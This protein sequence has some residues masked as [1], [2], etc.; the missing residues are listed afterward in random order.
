MKGVYYSLFNGISVDNLL[1]SIASARKRANRY[2]D[3]WVTNEGFIEFL[4]LR[5]HHWVTI[6]HQGMSINRHFDLQYLC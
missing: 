1:V 5:Y 6:D 4:G 3:I 2:G